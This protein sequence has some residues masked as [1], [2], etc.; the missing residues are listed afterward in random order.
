LLHFWFHVIILDRKKQYAKELIKMPKKIVILNGSPRKNGNTASLT[1]A[2][3]RG[4]EEAG[5]TVTEFFPA[6]M[7]IN[8]CLGC[9]KG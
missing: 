1:A 6:H 4:A 8:G 5:H 2:F 7:K 9:W 3:K